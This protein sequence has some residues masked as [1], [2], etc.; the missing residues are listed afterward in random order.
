MSRTISDIYG[1]IIA[2]K[3]AQA[4]LTPLAPQADTLANLLS[5]LN[6]RSKTAIWRLWAYIVAVAM[7]VHENLWDAFRLEVDAAAA[8]AIPHTLLWYQGKCLAFQ[9]GD[10]LVI[11]NGVPG[12]ATI[13]ATKQIVK[14]AATIED[15]TGLITIKLA[16]ETSGVPGPLTSTE[17][18]QFETYLNGIKEAGARTQT[19]SLAADK[20]RMAGVVFYN[21]IYAEATVRALVATAIDTYLATI[22]FN[23]KVNTNKLIDAIQAVVGVNDVVLNSFDYQIGLL[24]WAAVGREYQTFA[25]YAVYDATGHPLASA[26]T[27][28]PA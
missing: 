7:W 10:A 15:N 9:L 19:V 26:L 27:F 4:Q 14:R 24:P 2:L 8:R 23:G 16:K 22:P 6:S 1:S 21:A 5:A 13:D 12:Y 18:L 28:T 25:G 11:T 17:L 20:V 3:D